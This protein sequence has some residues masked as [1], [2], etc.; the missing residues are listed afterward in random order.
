MTKSFFLL[1]SSLIAAV[2]SFGQAQTVNVNAD[3]FKQLIEKNDGIVLD[4]RTAGEY[5]RGHIEGSTLI[6]IADR[7]FIDKTNLL[8]KDKPLYIYCLTGS[9]SHV[10]ANYLSQ[11]GFTRVY[12]LQRGIIEWQQ[13]GFQISQSKQAIVSKSKTFSIEEYKELSAS[14]ELVFID[15]HAPWCAPCKQMMPTVDK[16]RSEFHG[17]VK[18]EKIDVDANRQLAQHK[19]IASIPGFVLYKNGLEVWRHQGT[20]SYEELTALFD[21]YL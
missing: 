10:A 5:Q 11:K 15:F 2:V 3:Q 21:L 13:K 18:V 12:N 16:V 17:K 19:Q 20:I 4:V 8:Q 7:S 14:E 6:S 1:L 9:R